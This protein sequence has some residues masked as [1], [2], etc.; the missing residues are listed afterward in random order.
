MWP[1]TSDIHFC[2]LKL[3]TNPC[4]AAFGSMSLC[5][6]KCPIHRG[7]DDIMSLSAI[8]PNWKLFK[9]LSSGEWSSGCGAYV[10]TAN[11]S[12]MHRST[13]VTEAHTAS[14]HPESN[15]TE[16][17]RVT[18]IYSWMSI[19]KKWVSFL[20]L[21][22]Y[23]SLNGWR[24]N[25]LSVHWAGRCGTR[26]PSAGPHLLSIVQGGERTTQTLCRPI[27]SWSIVLIFKVSHACL[28]PCVIYSWF[29]LDSNEIAH[30]LLMDSKR[31]QKSETS[32]T[33]TAVESIHPL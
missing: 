21:Q 16:L 33:G 30:N 3:C 28:W 13:G 11:K 14:A 31:S 17:R 24:R 9:A 19:L 4:A 18:P 12:N 7:Q 5:L 20:R 25:L 27:G 8:T 6:C 1:W 15:M 32:E 22:N 26:S 10:C 2:P 23:L 29:R